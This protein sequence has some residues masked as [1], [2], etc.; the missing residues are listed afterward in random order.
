MSSPEPPTDIRMLAP[1][2][3]EEVN[4]II[5][6]QK[7]PLATSLSGIYPVYEACNPMTCVHYT[8]GDGGILVA[9]LIP[10]LL[11][12]AKSH[13]ILVQEDNLLEY[14]YIPFREKF[15][16]AP[17]LGHCYKADA[18][19]ISDNNVEEISEPYGHMSLCAARRNLAN[20][21][22]TVIVAYGAD[23][24]GQRILVE[25]MTYEGDRTV[26]VPSGWRLI[27]LGLSF[28]TDDALMLYK[29]AEQNARAASKGMYQYG[30]VFT[31]PE[32]K[33]WALKHDSEMLDCSV[34]EADARTIDGVTYFAQMINETENLNE[35]HLM[36]ARS[37]IPGAG[38]GLFVRPRSHHGERRVVIPKGRRICWYSKRALLPGS[39]D[40]ENTDYLLEVSRG[41]HPQRFD[42]PFYDGFNLGRYINQ[43]GLIEGL[44][45]MVQ[46][47][48]K[49]RGQ[50]MNQREV[51]NE[52]AKHVNCTYR[53][54]RGS[55]E[56]IS[57]K[58][59][60][61]SPLHSQ[62][63]FADYGLFKYWIVNVLSNMEKFDPNDVMLKAVLWCLLSEYSSW[64]DV[65]RR[66]YMSGH[67]ISQA[68]QDQFKL[69]P[70]PYPFIQA[71]RH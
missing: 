44:K 59:I 20:S 69:M 37:T 60:V 26:G 34:K 16:D 62:E 65:D 35:C 4:N 40:P 17:E 12:Y 57:S 7:L 58:D 68:I 70:C 46:S 49:Q 61:L 10:G 14:T 39:P 24:S 48:D 51:T 41:S 36:V 2:L 71:R 18:Q 42:A 67:N 29:D 43:G 55:L 9:E 19:R 1:N 22:R 30:E 33:P 11:E 6:T 47:S 54:T 50:N 31:G 15:H 27:K 38:Y 23:R 21:K 3:P 25:I 52:V 32:L 28:A 56:I 13:K 45:H 8:D 66:Y 53:C 63:L 5:T 64:S